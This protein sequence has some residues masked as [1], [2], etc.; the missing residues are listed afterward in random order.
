M[1][2]AT[3]VKTGEVRLSYAHL[4][5]PFSFD[6]SQEKKYSVSLII[7]KSD[8]KTIGALKSAYKTALEQG[9]EK[10]GKAFA[11]AEKN[12]PFIRVPGGQYGLLIDGDNEDDPNYK[13]SYVLPIK[14]KTAP[15]VLSLDTGTTRLTKE[16]GGEDKV[17]SG[18]YAKVSLNVYGFNTPVPGISAGLNN[19][20]KTRDGERFGG[21]APAEDDFADELKEI[22]DNLAD[23]I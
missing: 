11:K 22:E 9:V 21:A 15:G 5:E 7:P 2:A 8:T 20:L 23:L 4:F 12:A 1:E 16:N 19:V 17:Y 6:E 18:C 10:K 13:D 3:K 14:S